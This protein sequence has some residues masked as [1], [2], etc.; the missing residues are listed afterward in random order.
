MDEL[1]Y[2]DKHHLVE[3]QSDHLAVK[4][5]KAVKMVGFEKTFKSCEI[6]YIF[7]HFTE[8]PTFQSS[9]NIHLFQHVFK[10]IFIIVSDLHDRSSAR[11]WKEQGSKPKKG[12][13]LKQYN[14]L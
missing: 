13:I 1:V 5:L 8:K 3:R 7:N 11:I 12:H 9:P 14:S 10:N 6:I 2:L 4:A